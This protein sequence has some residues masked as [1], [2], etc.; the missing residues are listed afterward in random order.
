MS[1]TAVGVVWVALTDEQ[2]DYYARMFLSGHRI[3]L[4]CNQA[5]NQAIDLAVDRI[6]AARRQNKQEAHRWFSFGAQ[7]VGQALWKGAYRG[8]DR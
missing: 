5:D 8:G 6:V 3:P 4:F 7:K 2:V 1:S